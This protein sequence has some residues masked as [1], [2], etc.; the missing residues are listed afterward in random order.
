[1]LL[2]SFLGTNLA[3][4]HHQVRLRLLLDHRGHGQQHRDDGVVRWCSN[5]LHLSRNLW[6]NTGL[7]RSA[8]WPHHAGHSHRD[9]KCYGKLYLLVDYALVL[10]F[11]FSFTGNSTGLVHSRGVIRAAGEATNSPTR[12]TQPALRGVGARRDAAH[13]S[14][15]W[16]RGPGKFDVVC[17]FPPNCA[18]HA[19]S[20]R[21]KRC[22][23]SPS[24]TNASST[25]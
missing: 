17:S 19:S 15:L 22:F 10:L 16:Y 11:S 25:W 3:A 21:S 14:A 6:P 18:N 13:H 8:Q 5:L 20:I 4:N 23:A 24:C 12:G 9:S 2:S 7:D 1:M